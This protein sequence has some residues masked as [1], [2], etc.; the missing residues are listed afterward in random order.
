MLRFWA[1]LNLLLSTFLV[2]LL[3]A[4]A[5]SAESIVDK[6]RELNS[7]SRL[8]RLNHF[9]RSTS[10]V[11]MVIACLLASLTSGDGSLDSFFLPSGD[12]G[13]SLNIL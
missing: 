8:G 2:V 11:S 13:L 3:F 4:V 9:C 12:L 6:P 7:L 10:E 1:L 5:F